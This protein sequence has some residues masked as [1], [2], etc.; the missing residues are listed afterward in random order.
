MVL[1]KDSQLKEIHDFFDQVDVHGKNVIASLEATALPSPTASSPTPAAWGPMTTKKSTADYQKFTNNAAYEAR[2]LK[3][4][5]LS[6][7]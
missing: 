2:R 7:Y 1:L 3:S 4:L 5:F 6:L